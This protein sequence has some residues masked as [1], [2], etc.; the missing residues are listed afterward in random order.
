ME[1]YNAYIIY[2]VVSLLLFFIG[3]KKSI[4]KL[5]LC[6]IIATT[7]LASIPVLAFIAGIIDGVRGR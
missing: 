7:F 6:G 5:K 4:R 2:L 1:T 3:K